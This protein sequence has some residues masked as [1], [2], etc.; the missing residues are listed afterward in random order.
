MKSF[1]VLFVC[2]SNIFRSMTAEYCLN[3]Y[4]EKNRI[5]NFNVISAGIKKSTDKSEEHTFKELERLRIS[6]WHHVPRIINKKLLDSQDLIICMTKKHANI[7]S[8]EYNGKFDFKIVLFNKLAIGEDS[9]VLDVL[10]LLPNPKE[11]M[12]KAKIIATRI[13]MH[14][15]KNTPKLFE[16]IKVWFGLN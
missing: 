10:D 2:T 5:K 9:D 12:G 14:I 3:D 4:L 6:A 16:G 15:Y 1:N 11:D 8:N 13:I 7:I